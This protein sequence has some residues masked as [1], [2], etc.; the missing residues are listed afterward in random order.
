M[1]LDLFTKEE[2]WMAKRITKYALIILVTTALATSLIRVILVYTTYG[3]VGLQNLIRK[4]NKAPEDIVPA[5]QNFKDTLETKK[6][7]KPAA[8]APTGLVEAPV[9]LEIPSLGVQ[10]SI[11]VPETTN[12]SVLDAA[13][14]RAA[15]YYQG[16]GTPGNGNMLIFGHSTGFKIVRNQAY[17]VFNNIK[18]AKV[19]EYVYVKTASGTYTY[20]VRD[21]KHV[22]KYDTWINFN[23][24]AAMLTLSTCDSFGKSSDR[25]ILEA[26]FVGY[27]EN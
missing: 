1:A 14:S 27:K 12:V 11:E 10:T 24:A 3:Q 25:W 16:S 17:K 6:S 7:T 21:V 8:S 20:K 4:E 18:S 23:S 26:D 9:S 22:S 15:V 5:E 19:G 2:L 13:L